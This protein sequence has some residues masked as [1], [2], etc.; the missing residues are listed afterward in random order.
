VKGELQGS[1]YFRPKVIRE[2]GG[3]KSDVI[4]GIFLRGQGDG[5]VA[6]GVTV[7]GTGNRNKIVAGFL[8]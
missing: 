8:S 1:P 2:K 6:S 4:P 3:E 7:I 5:E